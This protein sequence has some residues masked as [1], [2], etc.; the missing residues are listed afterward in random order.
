MSLSCSTADGATPQSC[1]EI[2]IVFP[3]LVRSNY[4]VSCPRL[5]GWPN[6]LRKYHCCA[7]FVG[8]LAS[9]VCRIS[10]EGRKIRYCRTSWC[11]EYHSHLHLKCRWRGDTQI[12]EWVDSEGVL[13][14]RFLNEAARNPIKTSKLISQNSVSCLFHVLNI[15]I[16]RPDASSLVSKMRNGRN[17]NI[18]INMYS[19]KGISQLYRQETS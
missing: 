15:A 17:G 16:L 6:A 19:Q 13:M 18:N 3:L 2:S 5:V 12:V 4:T 8:R 1:Y 11:A 10:R 7:F 14:K 9:E